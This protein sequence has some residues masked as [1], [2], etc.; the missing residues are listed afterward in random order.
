MYFIIL[1]CYTTVYF[2]ILVYYTTVYFIILVCYTTVYFIILTVQLSTTTAQGHVYNLLLNNLHWPQSRAWLCVQ[3][4]T[5]FKK[6]CPPP[7]KKKTE[8]KEKKKPHIP[9]WISYSHASILWTQFVVLRTKFTFRPS[10]LG[11]SAALQSCLRCQTREFTLINFISP[12][13]T[14]PFHSDMSSHWTY[15]EVRFGQPDSVKITIML[16]R[17][18]LWYKDKAV[19]NTKGNAQSNNRSWL[20]Y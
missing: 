19:F 15:F 1:V 11:H 8:K 3:K 4:T 17:S 6:W 13:H 20:W 16:D 12:L 14:Q 10:L 2:I 5:L 18:W 7:Q 9:F